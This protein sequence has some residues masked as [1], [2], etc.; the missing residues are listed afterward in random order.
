MM[1]ATGCVLYAIAI[2]ALAIAI[3]RQA[4]V[5]ERAHGE[6]AARRRRHPLRGVMA[7]IQQEKEA[8]L[9]PLERKQGQSNSHHTQ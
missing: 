5:M 7:T 2:I 8:A 1:L 3:W 4:G 6:L 9:P